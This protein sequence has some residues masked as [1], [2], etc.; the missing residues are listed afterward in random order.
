MMQFVAQDLI[1][2]YDPPAVASWLRAD[3]FESVA[4]H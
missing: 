1:L 3:L 4:H 2:R